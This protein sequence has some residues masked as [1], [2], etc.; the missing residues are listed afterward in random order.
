MRYYDKI[1]RTEVAIPSDNTVAFGDGIIDWWFDELPD[2][3]TVIYDNEGMPYMI[4]IGQFKK[5]IVVNGVVV[6]GITQEEIDEE[7]ALI[8]RA[9]IEDAINSL[10]VTYNGNDY[11]AGFEAQ[12]RM[13]NAYQMAIMS[14][15]PVVVFDT[16]H[17]IQM[18]SKEDLDKIGEL[19]MTEIEKIINHA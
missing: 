8:E 4:E 2:N 11:E 15:K 3:K 7:N 18:L 12:H 6:E 10:V 14:Q 5:P 9:K 17:K 13:A 16:N 1:T 19:I